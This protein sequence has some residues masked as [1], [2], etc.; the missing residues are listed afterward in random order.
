MIERAVCGDM[1]SPVMAAPAARAT[2]TAAKMIA[3]RR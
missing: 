3:F 1:V 2:A